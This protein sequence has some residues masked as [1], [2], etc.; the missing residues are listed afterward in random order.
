MS[1]VYERTEHGS[2]CGNRWKFSKLADDVCAKDRGHRGAHRTTKAQEA[3]SH[4]WFGSEG[5]PAEAIVATVDQE[6][7]QAEINAAMMGDGRRAVREMSSITRTDYAIEYRDGRSVRLRLVD[8]PA[9]PGQ[10]KRTPL[11]YAVV[12]AGNRE[13]A[14]WPHIRRKHPKNE[15]G[16]SC[17]ADNTT[18]YSY[19]NCERF[20]PARNASEDSKPGTI[21]ALVW[22]QINTRAR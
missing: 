8:A 21:G 16:V 6:T 15:Y 1:K 17:T 7:G 11:G 3:H 12:T 5:I 19:R 22:A 13:F 4:S 18:Y 14:V 10:P 2:A 20:G 9:E